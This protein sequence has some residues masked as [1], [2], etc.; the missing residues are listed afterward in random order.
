MKRLSVIISYNTAPS[1][2]E[3]SLVSLLENRP[4]DC[5]ILVV[6]NIPYGN[7]Y[8]LE[9]E[10]VR[11]LPRNSETKYENKT[12]WDCIRT[13]L[14][15]S[16]SAYVF[17]MPAGTEFH[18]EWADAP[19]EILDKNQDVGAF[20]LDE[21]L[22]NGGFFRRNLLLKY[23]ADENESQLPGETDGDCLS[24]FVSLLQKDDWICA[25]AEFEEMEEESGTENVADSENVAESENRT[26]QKTR[27]ESEDFSVTE[28][29]EISVSDSVSKYE[30]LEPPAADSALESVS[31]P[32]ADFI[33]K[34]VSPSASEP[35]PI[36]CTSPEN[37]FLPSNAGP[38]DP[39]IPEDSGILERLCTFCR[40]IFSRATHV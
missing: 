32:A 35:A 12:A 24:S 40:K 14:A 17:L 30:S 33:P 1:Q 28:S 27:A 9:E 29:P 11:F 23:V 34:S 5:D 39:N 31:E 21:N 25:L 26:V 8:A 19:L 20:F 22:Q 7:P 2:L 18:S 6:K 4:E 10:E 3:D 16:D 36:Y 13:G 15:A 38:E 37:H